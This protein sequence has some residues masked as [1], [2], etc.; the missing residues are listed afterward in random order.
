M[1]ARTPSTGTGLFVGRVFGIPIYFAPSWFLIAALLT[2]IYAPTVE[3]SVGGTGGGVSYLVAFGF[4]VL[5]YASVLVHELGHSLVARAF[6][7]PVR[8]ITIHAFVGF[9][10]IE[11]EPPTPGREA[12]V[13]VAG[14]AVSV[15]LAVV[16]ALSTQLFPPGGIPRLL[17]TAL[18]LSNAL[19]AV[20]NLLPGLPLDGGRVFRALVWRVSKSQVTG[21]TV[22]AWVGRVI[23]VAL[24]VGGTIWAVQRQT[25]NALYDVLVAILIGS[26][27]W[28]GASSALRS[29]KLRTALPDLAARRLTRRALPVAADLPLAEAL[30]R[31][32]IDGAR[33]LVVVDAA[34]RPTGIVSESAVAATPPPRRPWIAAG[35]LA[36][37]LAPGLTLTTELA[38]ADLLRALQAAP[39]EEYLVVEPSGEVYGVLSTSDVAEAMSRA[40]VR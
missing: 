16:G 1:S 35:T 27:V 28:S 24:G 31:L 5:L 9:S 19:I 15:L 32:G 40:G 29:A 38:G 21:T 20:L 12:L 34:G 14:P 4:A 36:R 23:G 18:T 37:T 26:F 13:A 8:R 39:A 30:R 10:E 7:L 33:A 11:Q 6:R 22:S 3:Q 2:V 25:P 17:S